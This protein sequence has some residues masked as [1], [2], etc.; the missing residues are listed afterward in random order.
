MQWFVVLKL[1]LLWVAVALLYRLWLRGP[2][3]TSGGPVLERPAPPKL[4]HPLV[5]QAAPEWRGK[6]IS[7]ASVSTAEAGHPSLIVVFD[8]H[9]DTCVENLEQY[10]SLGQQANQARENFFLVSLGSQEDTLHVIDQRVPADV[11]VTVQPRMSAP[12]SRIFQIS[13][14]PMYFRIDAN[15]TV[16]DSGHPDLLSHR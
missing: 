11:P 16:I 14:I 5:G 13:S 10:V 7:G 2:G 8:P 3:H 6:S 12:F 9:C 4:F 1:L 15:R